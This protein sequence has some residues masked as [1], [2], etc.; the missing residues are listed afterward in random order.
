MSGETGSQKGV[1]GSTQRSPDY[2]PDLHKWPPKAEAEVS[3][4]LPGAERGELA[5]V[6]SS[7]RPLGARID[8]EARSSSKSKH[9][10]GQTVGYFIATEGFSREGFFH[11]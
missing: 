8:A 2:K 6:S 4:A 7:N 9:A 3:A 10:W 11:P 5:E 1:L